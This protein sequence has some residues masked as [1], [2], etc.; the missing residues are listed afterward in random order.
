MP[1]KIDPGAF[2][3]G[4]GHPKEAQKMVTFSTRLW[5]KAIVF[6]L[7]WFS[8]GLVS[9]FAQLCEM[10]Y[11]HSKSVGAAGDKWQ[12][13]C[14]MMMFF[15]SHFSVSFSNSAVMFVTRSSQI[16][17]RNSVPLSLESGLQ[18]CSSWGSKGGCIFW[19]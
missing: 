9:D 4:T 14:I 7:F 5:D 12:S 6:E 10:H 15:F 13:M 1:E 16:S 19:M 2:L 3:M 18:H 11:C 8:S 17:T